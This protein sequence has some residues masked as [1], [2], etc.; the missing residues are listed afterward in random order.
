MTKLLSITTIVALTL[1]ATST[2][3]T[4]D[5][6]S[7]Q[8]MRRFR[9]GLEYRLIIVALSDSYA[10]LGS[11][12]SDQPKSVAVLSSIGGRGRGVGGRARKGYC[13]NIDSFEFCCRRLRYSNLLLES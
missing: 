8:K 3:S 9:N 1:W 5:A 11:K 12:T 10:G 6:L 13:V 2:S 7:L 4:V